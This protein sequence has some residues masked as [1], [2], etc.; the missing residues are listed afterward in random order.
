MTYLTTANKTT[1]F[2]EYTLSANQT[3]S[4]GDAILFDTKKTTG[5]D[6]VSINSTTGE[7][8]LST[9]SAYWLTVNICIDRA[10]TGTS[11]HVSFYDSSG[12]E[13]LEEGGSYGADY[14]IGTSSNRYSPTFTCQLVVKNPTD[15]YYAKVKTVAANSE[16][17]TRT[18]LFIMEIS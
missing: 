18:N 1:R 17:H 6:S 4:S 5:G 14:T 16:V 2:V 15:T 9:S 8:T 3:V 7:I 13:I 11:F 10:S 12:T